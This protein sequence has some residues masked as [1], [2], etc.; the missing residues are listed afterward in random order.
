MSINKQNY[1]AYFLDYIE[2]CLDDSATLEMMAFIRNN[3]ELKEELE[4]VG[5]TPC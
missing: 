3:P 5:I 1:E 4:M 2:G